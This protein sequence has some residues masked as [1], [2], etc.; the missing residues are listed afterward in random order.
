MNTRIAAI[1][2]IFFAAATPAQEPAKKEVNPSSPLFTIHLT[3]GSRLVETII[4]QKDVEVYTKYGKLIIPLEDIR[5]IEFGFRCPPETEKEIHACIESLKSS[6]FKERQVAENYLS[7]MGHLSYPFVKKISEGKGDLESVRRAKTAM[8]KIRLRAPPNLLILRNCDTLQTK[9]LAIT[10]GIQ[11]NA[12]RVYSPQ[13]GDMTIK[14]HD[15]LF[16]S[17]NNDSR[18]EMVTI[19]AAQYGGLPEKWLGAGA[20]VY[21]NA[22]LIVKTEGQVDLWPQGPGQYMAGPKGYSTAGKNSNFMAGALIGRIG[23]KGRIFLIGEN[24]D[25]NPT[26]EGELFLRIV[27]GPWENPSS[28][29]YRVYVT[30]NRDVR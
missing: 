13:I 17:R 12:F 30:I 29:T 4:H 21:R 5:K 25:D 20:E 8:E 1:V 19:D 14:L 27:Q 23:E 28:G 10:G 24:Y 3:K 15:I 26:E 6:D 11:G 9:E 16:V 2:L 18:G 7:G 22:R